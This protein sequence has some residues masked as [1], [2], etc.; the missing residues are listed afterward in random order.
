MKYQLEFE[1]K[2]RKRVIEINKEG[3]LT[4][5][6]EELSKIQYEI[7]VTKTKLLRELI[8]RENSDEVFLIN[9][10]NP[11][12]EEEEYKE[13]KSSDYFELLKFLIRDGYID[14]THTDYMT[15]FYEESLTANDK[16]FLRRITDKRGA[17]YEY[18]LK[19]VQKVLS[20]SAL[21]IVDFSEEE[22]LNFD[23]L[24]G[25]LERQSVT[26]YQE[27]L[28]TLIDQLQSSKDIDFISKYYDTENYNRLFIQKLNEQ[29]T[30]MFSYILNNKAIQA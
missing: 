19:E 14:E 17:E 15:Y 1:K 25:L 21:R 10:I 20:S 11:V 30:E 22:T 6:E 27:Y 7:S 18:K 4:E 24:N 28:R 9:S 26:K 8:T 3:R 16:T 5:Y 29:W 23:L 12:G 13:I 2:E